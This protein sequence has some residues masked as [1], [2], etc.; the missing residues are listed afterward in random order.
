MSFLLFLAVIL[1]HTYGQDLFIPSALF[2]LPSNTI[3]SNV[4]WAGTYLDYHGGV[5]KNHTGTFVY[6]NNGN[7]IS[8][9]VA[10]TIDDLTLQK[11][12]FQDTRTHMVTMYDVYPNG[13]CSYVSFGDDLFNC[14]DWYFSDTRWNR[15]CDYYLDVHHYSFDAVGMT[16][17]VIT[18]F[19]QEV[20]LPDDFRT[21]LY[22]FYANVT[23]TFNNLCQVSPIQIPTQ[24]NF[25]Q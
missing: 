1:C 7:S 17:D 16:N 15:T 9:V 20:T 24:C 5:K 22:I 12:V 8:Y 10:I 18:E 6:C 23:A 14:T 19:T 13:V 21:Q 11:F 3:F 2:N 25:A 4:N